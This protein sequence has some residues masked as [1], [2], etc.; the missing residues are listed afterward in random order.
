MHGARH[1]AHAFAA[2]GLAAL[3]ADMLAAADL[4]YVGA[5]DIDTVPFK[6]FPV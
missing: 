4:V 6:R 2:T 1:D 3:I 5:E